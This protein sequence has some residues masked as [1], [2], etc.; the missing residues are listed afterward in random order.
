MDPQS[1]TPSSP[2]IDVFVA[3]SIARRFYLEN[4]SKSEIADEFLMSRFKV[5][6]ILADAV[7]QGIVQIDITVPVKI[8]VELSL[9]LKERFGLSYVTVIDH[10]QDVRK[11]PPDELVRW[12]GAA[13]ARLISDLIDEGDVLGLAW[14]RSVEALGKAITKLAPCQVVQLTGSHP[15]HWDC[16]ESVSAVLRAAAAGGGAAYPLHVPLLVPN[17]LT[18]AIL[19]RQPGIAATLAQFP[20]VSKAVVEIGAWA[21]GLSTVYDVLTER[22]RE[23]YRDL[24][25]CAEMCGHLFDTHGNVLPTELND[26]VISIGVEDLRRVPD[27]IGVAGD[28]GKTEAI[29]TILRSGLLTG[30]VTDGSVARRILSSPV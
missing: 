9:A 1:A 28:V 18:A 16:D 19:G 15:D 29:C 21:P 3:A 10:C 23:R 30:L 26:R 24:G 8:D 6:R 5:A 17:E 7:S 20:Q 11:M 25:V 14:G 22:E 27:V 4:R 12:L 2:A 13:A